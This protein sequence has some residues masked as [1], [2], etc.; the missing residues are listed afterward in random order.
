MTV[1]HEYA[2]E[3]PRSVRYFTCNWTSGIRCGVSE[4]SG[5]YSGPSAHNVLHYQLQATLSFRVYWA[6]FETNAHFKCLFRVY[7]ISSLRGGPNF[8]RESTFCSKISFGGSLFIKKLLPGGN[9]FLG[10][11][12]TMT[13]PTP[14]RLAL[15]RL[16]AVL[17]Q[18]AGL[19]TIHIKDLRP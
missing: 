17:Q 19:V 2:S 1:F 18:E 6:K 13:D 11:I 3:A 8:Q 7:I 16:V 9:Q 10:S 4:V 15:V 12:F 14:T 5:N